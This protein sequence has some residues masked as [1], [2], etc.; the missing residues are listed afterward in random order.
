MEKRG[1]DMVRLEKPE[2]VYDVEEVL[3]RDALAVFPS[4]NKDLDPTEQLKA[5]IG[6]KR[7]VTETELQEI[8]AARG[9][10]VDDG[11]LAP[12]KPLAEVL[13]ERKK[14]KQDAFDAQ[15]KQMKTGA[16]VALLSRGGFPAQQL[17]RIAGACWPTEYLGLGPTFSPQLRIKQQYET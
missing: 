12:E 8:K 4:M 2:E 9:L 14:A 7:F 11:T 16:A 1:V 5:A 17:H 10:T 6:A 13:A 3:G 15:W